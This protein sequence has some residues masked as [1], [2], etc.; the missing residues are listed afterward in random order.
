MLKIEIEGKCHLVLVDSG[1]SPSVMKP[2]ISSS[3]LQPTQTATRGITGN[4]V[5]ASRTQYI[6]F[7]EGKR[8]FKHEFLIT[9]LDVEFSG[10]LSMDVLK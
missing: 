6:T 2:G 9:P 10:I 4:K 5:K 3:E 1:A 8:N 7:R